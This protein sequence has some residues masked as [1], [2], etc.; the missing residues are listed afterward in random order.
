M[1]ESPIAPGSHELDQHVPIL[2]HTALE[3][4]KQ[5]SDIVSGLC[6]IFSFRS[7]EGRLWKW[8][9]ESSVCCASMKIGVWIPRTYVKVGCG[10]VHL[11]EWSA[12]TGRSWVLPGWPAYHKQQASDSMRDLISECPPKQ[13][14]QSRDGQSRTSDVN[15][16]PSHTPSERLYAPPLHPTPSPHK[17]CRSQ[18]TSRDGASLKHPHHPLG[19][20]FLPRSICS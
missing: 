16:C 17:E 9:G 12:E 4:A 19:T 5:G 14:R 6:G 7:I 11:W 20:M 15:C 10:G 13:Q 2:L 1:I 18:A 8:P 3:C